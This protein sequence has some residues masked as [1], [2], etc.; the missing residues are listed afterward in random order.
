MLKEEQ[1]VLADFFF[2]AT[3]QSDLLH[4]ILNFTFLDGLL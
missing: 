4:L 1:M 3:G 2:F